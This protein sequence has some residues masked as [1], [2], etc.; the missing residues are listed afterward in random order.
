MEEAIEVVSGRSIKPG[1]A[2][3]TGRY[4][5]PECTHL[6]H[7][8]DR[9]K[10]MYVAHYPAAPR[11]CPLLS[12]G[13]D[14][15]Q[16]EAMARAVLQMQIVMVDGLPQL[17]YL[18]SKNTQPRSVNAD[19]AAAN[20]RRRMLT[21]SRQ[22]RGHDG[23][24]LPK[25]VGHHRLQT[26]PRRP[27]PRQRS[28]DHSGVL[29]RQS[30]RPPPGV[31]RP[32]GISKRLPPVRMLSKAWVAVQVHLPTVATAEFRRWLAIAAIPIESQ[33][34]RARL[35]TPSYGYVGDATRFPRGVPVSVLTGD[36]AANITSTTV[37]PVEPT[38]LIRSD[39]YMATPPRHQQ[40]DPLLELTNRSSSRRQ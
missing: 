5:C 17:L 37:R 19:T 16:I 34:T 36:S 24:D 39:E 26:A 31:N 23:I 35:M 14:R 6:V 29:G 8:V 18:E 28:T 4:V 25:L 13:L 21:G 40:P 15:R 20:S 32:T 38:I 12:T 7:P 2:S 22:S 11:T 27:V 10:S 9:G 1:R 3:R 33:T 30:D